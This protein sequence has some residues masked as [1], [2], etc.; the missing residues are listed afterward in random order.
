MARKSKV[1]DGEKVEV[2][3]KIVEWDPYSLTILTEV[4]GKIAFGDITE[5][6]T[7]KEEVDEVTGLSRKVV[8]EQ[9]GTNL[10]ATTVSSKMSQEKPQ[11]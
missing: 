9:A 6:V 11:N 7:M 2:G 4:G 1:K 3:Q 5:G 8:I 10:Q